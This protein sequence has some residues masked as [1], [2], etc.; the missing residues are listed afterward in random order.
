MTVFAMAKQT[1]Q[2]NKSNKG[3]G[4]VQRNRN[5]KSP[6]FRFFNGLSHNGQTKREDHFVTTLNKL[7]DKPLNS[8]FPFN[9]RA[10]GSVANTNPNLY[11]KGRV[12]ANQGNRGFS[13]APNAGPGPSFGFIAKKR[14]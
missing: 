2:S 10:F 4:G 9:T 3:S 13:I 11:T 12:G 5:T 7:H 1:S 6:H 14:F 8:P